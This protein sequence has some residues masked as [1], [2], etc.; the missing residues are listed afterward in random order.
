MGFSPFCPPVNNH[1]PVSKEPGTFLLI[2]AIKFITVAD[3]YWRR[4]YIHI[5]I[6]WRFITIFIVLL[7]FKINYSILAP[8]LFYSSF[9]SYLSWICA[10]SAQSKVVSTNFRS[11]AKIFSTLH[12]QE[13]CVTFAQKLCNPY[14]EV[15]I[16]EYS[17]TKFFS[18]VQ[19]KNCEKISPYFSLLGV[20]NCPKL[21]FFG[22]NCQ[23]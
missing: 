22:K 5:Q 21:H 1:L 19:R 2:A 15:A 8:A 23:V 11:K 13:I 7:K 12:L 3:W 10:F 4:I 20:E 6:K 18:P 17:A 14:C 16:G 9:T